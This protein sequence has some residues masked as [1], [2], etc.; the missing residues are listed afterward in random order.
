[1]IAGL[2]SN[3]AEFG[4][5]GRGA[6]WEVWDRAA[7]KLER[8]RDKLVEMASDLRAGDDR[9]QALLDGRRRDWFGLLETLLKFKSRTKNKD[10]VKRL[11]ALD[12]WTRTAAA[13]AVTRGA[14]WE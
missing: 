13:L 2:G 14:N 7:D 6:D 11:E 9:P 4:L 8:D 5:P 3:I 10:A 1:M 12:D